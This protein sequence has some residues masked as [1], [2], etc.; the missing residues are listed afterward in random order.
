MSFRALLLYLSA[1]RSQVERVML[2]VSLS[3]AVVSLHAGIQ[4]QTGFSNGCLGLGLFRGS[5]AMC[6]T[7]IH[8][9]V[10]FLAGL[11]LVFITAGF[12]IA[13][14]ALT[15][16]YF[17]FVYAMPSVGGWVGVARLVV[18]GG[19]I[20]LA[21]FC[22]VTA[23]EAS[24]G[25]GLLAVILVLVSGTSLGLGLTSALISPRT[26]SGFLSAS[27]L[28]SRTFRRELL[29]VIWYVA[30]AV[31]LWGATYASYG[32]WSPSTTVPGV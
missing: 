6:S 16:I 12:C 4:M 25:P 1:Y 31:V 11:D 8:G 27:R 30:L 3:G 32:A 18:L 26:R 24:G 2:A 10:P 23:I 19:G 20:G 21:A 17:A 22:V 14:A 15:V 9:G 5:L 28:S 13:V 7:W 29:I